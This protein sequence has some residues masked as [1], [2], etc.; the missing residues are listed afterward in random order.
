MKNLNLKILIIFLISLYF[1]ELNTLEIID[2]DLEQP[3]ELLSAVDDFIDLPIG[4]ISWKTFSETGMNEYSFTDDNG[5]DWIGFRPVFKEK[6]KNL[7]S[8]EVLIQGYMFP[9]EQDEKQK[10]FLLGPFPLTCPYHPH[11]SSNLLIE[12]HAIKPVNFSYDAI[13]IKGKL[14]LVP[15]DDEFNIF[16]RLK[17][18]KQIFG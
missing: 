15:I 5:N 12:V 16:Y 3:D 8:R 9:L 1:K 2:S 10:L 17:D 7:E 18:A 14:E 11:T 4:G 6:I 13:N